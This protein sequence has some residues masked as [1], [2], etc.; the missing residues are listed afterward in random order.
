MKKIALTSLLAVF[1]V[2][3][4]HAANVIDG[5]PI[6]MPNAGHFY[7]VSSIDTSSNNVDVFK[8]GEHV[9]YGIADWWTVDLGTSLTADDWFDST[10]WNELNVNTT[11]R[12]VNNT[13]WKW[14]LL[15]G[16]EVSPILG[17]GGHRFLHGSFF[18]IEDTEYT[19]TYGLRAGYVSGDL[20]IAGH[21]VSDYKNSE[22]FNWRTKG[23]HMLRA[24]V[25]AQYV[26]SDEWNLVGGAEYIKSLNQYNTKLG[27]W[28]VTL[29]ANYNID[30]TKYVG[31]YVSKDIQHIHDKKIIDGEVQ[32]GYWEIQDG[33]GFG[34]KFGIDF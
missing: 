22:S 32:D 23:W 19:W 31:V 24:G 7:S 10:Q 34:A 18:G 25:D 6:Y 27:E 5:N 33:F 29:G 20:T 26:L 28:K 13:N 1:A 15:A 14:D 4:A 17:S 11:I 30:E 16:Y 2:S 21:V 9:G 12:F 3:G 8:F